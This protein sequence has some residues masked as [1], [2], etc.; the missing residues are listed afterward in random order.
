MMLL[1][2][3]TIILS[4]AFLVSACSSDASTDTNKANING[5]MFTEGKQIVKLFAE[6]YNGEDDKGDQAEELAT[7]F[8]EKFENEYS[9]G[10][11]D[12]VFYTSIM[13]LKAQFTSYFLAEYTGK[14][15]IELGLIKE[16]IR[17]T[18]LVIR[19]DFGISFELE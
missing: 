19:E 1:K 8:L 11:Y 17:G 18:L 2:K 13:A 6:F 4:F 7:S 12:E 16:D 3:L 14:D 9:S 15:A 10:S 5:E